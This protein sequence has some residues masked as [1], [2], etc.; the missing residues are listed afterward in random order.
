M[1]LRLPERQPRGLRQQRH[2]ARREFRVAVQPRAHRRAAQRQLHQRLQRLVHPRHAQLHLPRVAL[3]FLPQPHGRRIHQV[4]AADLQHVPERPPLARQ[5]GVQRPQRRPQPPPQLHRHGHMHRRGKGVV[6]GLAQV[7]VVIRVHRFPGPHRP[8][9]H[10][11]HP[12]GDHLIHIH[13]RARPGPRL[14]NVQ[15]EVPV[16]RPRRHLRRRRGDPP[17]LLHWQQP[18]LRIRLRTRRLDVAIGVD[19]RQ[20]HAPPADG[21]IQ[22]CPLRGRPIKRLRRHLHLTH[23]VLF[24]AFHDQGYNQ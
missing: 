14:V 6:G 19:H 23:A 9:R 12:V 17:R 4:R 1:V 11:G 5:R 2:R 20:G 8:P 22:H 24:S 16:Q 3:E 21:K 13:V 7:H 15:H 10:L 18:Q